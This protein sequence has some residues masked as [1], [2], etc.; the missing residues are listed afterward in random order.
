M[1]N[2]TLTSTASRK[3][4]TAVVRALFRAASV[5]PTGLVKAGIVYAATLIICF[6]AWTP[7]SWP[8]RYLQTYISPGDCGMYAAGTTIMYFC[9]AKVA[10]MT[11]AGPILL[12]ILVMVLRS[13]VMKA[14]G[15]LVEKLPPETHFLTAPIVATLLFML[16]WSAVHHDADDGSGF[17]SQK[18][19]PV[20]IALYTFG[21]SQY[22]PLLQRLLRAFFARRDRIRRLWRVG[23]AFAV[24]LFISL[25]LTWQ[26]RV[27]ETAYKVQLVLLISLC[28]GYL[29]LAPRQGDLLTG[30]R[31]MMS[32]EKKA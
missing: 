12:T 23:F 20:V 7:L 4:V 17:L 25:Y 9:S 3:A 14:T 24:P 2:E 27:S 30:M 16:T 15:K 32:R 29:A 1:A 8:A 5:D 21:V 19:F 11:M 22:S 28:T 31:A 10:A 13:P 26:A 6:F 18:Y